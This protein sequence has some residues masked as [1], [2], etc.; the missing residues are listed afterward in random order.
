MRICRWLNEWG[1]LVLPKVIKF[2]RISPVSEFGKSVD[3]Q[4][5]QET[6]GHPRTTSTDYWLDLR[7]VHASTRFSWLRARWQL[8]GYRAQRV[9]FRDIRRV[10][11]PALQFW[12]RWMG[13]VQIGISSVFVLGHKTF[14]SK[15]FN[16][17]HP[18]NPQ[19]WTHPWSFHRQL[20]GS[21]RS[22]L[23]TTIYQIITVHQRP[24][25]IAA[26]SQNFVQRELRITAAAVESHFWYKRKDERLLPARSSYSTWVP[27]RGHSS[28]HKIHNH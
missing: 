13:L 3:R 21:C 2:I 26:I 25:E 6:S 17:N 12:W 15:K 20:T 4:Y 18:I 22:K 28:L 16:L 27:R 19:T 8:C 14:L 24:P 23:Y 9:P 10:G 5:G 1:W 7:E 11:V